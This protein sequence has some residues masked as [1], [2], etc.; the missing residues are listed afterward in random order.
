MTLCRYATAYA[1]PPVDVSQD[2]TSTRAEH[3]NGV[4]TIYF[5]RPLVANDD[6]DISLNECRYFLFGWGGDATIETQE[7]GYH[8]T[9]PIVSQERICLPSPAN[10]PAG[11]WGNGRDLNDSLLYTCIYT[12]YPVLQVGGVMGVHVAQVYILYSEKIG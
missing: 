10:C 7:I 5:R 3:S 12:V 11:G 8:P 2:I 1:P 4:T 6:D 9:T